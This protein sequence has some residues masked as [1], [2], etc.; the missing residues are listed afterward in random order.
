MLYSEWLLEKHPRLKEVP[1]S[2][3]LGYINRA[4]SETKI[5]RASVH[6]SIL[7]L[8]IFA[9]DLALGIFQYFHSAS[10]PYWLCMGSAV[11]M[12]KLIADKFGEIVIIK[13]L[14]VMVA[15]A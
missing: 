1:S 14:D 13:A 8:M 2:T 9:T 10:L 15:S 6:V 12:A 4:K 7:I 11:L 5:I 3:T